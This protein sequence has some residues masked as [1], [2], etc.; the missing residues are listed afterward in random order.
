MTSTPV[1][2]SR[3][4]EPESWTLATYERTA[5]YAA[6]RT[7]LTMEPDAIIAMVKEAG[8][9]GRGGAGFPTG[10]KWGFIPQGDGKPHYLV[11]NAD[12][13]EPGTCKDAPLMMAD[14]HS[15]IEG[16]VIASFAVRC[17]HAFIYLRGELVH[18]GRRLQSAIDEAQ[19]A[20]YLGANILGSGFDLSLTLHRGAGAYICGE[21]TA[22]LDS[23]EGYRGQPRLRPPFPATHGLYQSPTVVNNVESIATVPWIVRKG[24]DW[25]RS[26]GT[27][28]SPGPKIVSISGHVERPGQYEVPL[29]TTFATLLEM[30][31]GMRAGATLKAWTPGGSS[32]PLLTAR[33]VDTALDF[34]GVVA[35]GS[36]LGTAALMVLDESVCMV[37]TCLRLTEFYAHE[38]CGKCTPC[39]EGTYWMVQILARLES[40]VGSAEDLD[41]LLDTCDNIFGRAFCALGDGAVSPI[42]SGIQYFRDE[43]VQHYESGGCPFA[44]AAGTD[45]AGE[46]VAAG[47]R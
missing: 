25:F 27:E 13:G 39:R 32:T 11:V 46:L 5:G 22:L 41:T 28:K 35:A 19:A 1:L 33:H 10:M 26:M 31:G 40:G 6:L 44:A 47:A 2:T 15:L 21:E 20:G 37:R 29:G 8:L 34:E 36:L 4:A 43:F 30:A 45:A 24:V 14:P 12:E 23:L 18:A 38:S 7:A 16:I 42:V 3:W 9:R 17:H